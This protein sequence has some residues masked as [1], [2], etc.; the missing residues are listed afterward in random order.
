MAISVELLLYLPLVHW[1]VVLGD[2]FFL[3]FFYFM[4]GVGGGGKMQA[5]KMKL[6][7]LLT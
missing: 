3:D 2:L 1:L 7:T 6:T 5:L 4:K